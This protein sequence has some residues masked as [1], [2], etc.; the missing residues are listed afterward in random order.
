MP[1]RSVIRVVDGESVEA[2]DVVDADVDVDG[3]VAVGVCV[4]VTVT[5]WPGVLE[6][7]AASNAQP[8]TAMPHRT[9]LWVMTKR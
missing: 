2:A 7:H 8:A 1:G 6:E 4:L 5:T 9:A 3:P